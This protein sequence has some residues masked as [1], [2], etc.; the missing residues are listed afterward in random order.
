MKQFG[1]HFLK[2]AK[3]RLKRRSV[4]LHDSIVSTLELCLQLP[5]ITILDGKRVSELLAWSLPC[6]SV[7]STSDHAERDTSDT[8]TILHVAFYASYLF[9][10]SAKGCT[11]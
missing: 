1:N 3:E 9:A 2:R 5:C 8:T 4:Q 7:F 6:P 10:G 11:A